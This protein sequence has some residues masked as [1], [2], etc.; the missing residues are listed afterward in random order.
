MKKI[1][2]LATL[3]LTL[4]FSGVANAYQ[5]TP[6]EPYLN[7]DKNQPLV[8]EYNGDAEYAML[9][10]CKVEH[11]GADYY[12]I[13]IKYIYFYNDPDYGGNA[14]NTRFFRQVKD[15][16]SLPQYSNNFRQT[17]ITIPSWK[18]KD[19]VERAQNPNKGGHYPNFEF[20]YNPRAYYLFCAAYK[21]AFT[22][23]YIDI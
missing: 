19:A 18:D 16:V 10:T 4:S 20:E 22:K 8:W 13:S 2:L 15:G 1:L 11:D 12:E 9:D 14:Y 3:I 7:G 21:Q 17:W 23:D 5:S 6:F